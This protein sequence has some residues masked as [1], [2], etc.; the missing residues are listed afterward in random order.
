MRR[1]RPQTALCSGD[2]QVRPYV[3]AFILGSDEALR[4]YNAGRT[5]LLQYAQSENR[6]LLPFEGL[7]EFETCISA[8]KRCLSLADRMAS[9]PENPEIERTVRH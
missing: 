4:A 9:H 2:R 7:A 8:V 1:T 3:H 5:H 6:T